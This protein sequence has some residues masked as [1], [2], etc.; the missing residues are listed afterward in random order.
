MPFRCFNFNKVVWQ[1]SSGEVTEMGDI[2][3][4]TCAVLF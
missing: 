3:T 1:Y 4:V 2:H